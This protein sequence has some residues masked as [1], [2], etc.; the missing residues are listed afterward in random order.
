[1]NMI[2][3]QTIS[4]FELLSSKYS[5]DEYSRSSQTCSDLF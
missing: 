4:A 5:F 3:K 2:R 1:M